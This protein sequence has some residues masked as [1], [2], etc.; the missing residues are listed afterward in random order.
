M[1]I[2]ITGSS[3]FIGFHLS[4]LFLSKGYKVYGIDSMNSYYNVKLKRK[5]L[6]V[7]KKYENFSFTKINIEN[8]KNLILYLKNSNQKL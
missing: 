5:R 6:S 3:G 7:L 4:K 1:K 8:E 2:L